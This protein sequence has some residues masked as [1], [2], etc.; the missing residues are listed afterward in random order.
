M[1]GLDG[2]DAAGGGEVG[3]VG[4]ESGGTEV[5]AD[6]NTL[7]ETGLGDEVPGAGEAEVV[8]ARLGGGHVG[9]GHD[10]LDD[11][12]VADLIAHDLLKVLVEVL[13]LDVDLL[14]GLGVVLLETLGVESSL[15]VLKGQGV[16]ED[17]LV[18]DAAV[19]AIVLTL[20]EVGV[21]SCGGESSEESRAVDGGL[22]FDCLGGW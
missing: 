10:G 14:K 5:G 4:D 6:T 17:L 15:E 21:G 22:H 13:A 3:L 18:R 16:V 2:Q 19:S 12:N 20:L 7:E 1:A 8:G 9:R 11:S